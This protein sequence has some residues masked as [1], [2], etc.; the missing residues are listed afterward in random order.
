MR[1]AAYAAKPRVADA[2]R[3]AS[4]GHEGEAFVHDAMTRMPAAGLEPAHPYGLRILSPLRLPFRQAGAAPAI[5][6][7]ANRA[8][9]SSCL[10]CALWN[11]TAPGMAA[12]SAATSW[13]VAPWNLMVQTRLRAASAAIQRRTSASSRAG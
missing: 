1:P 12:K 11:S 2:A 8:K 5:G 4:E 13:S 10:F 6:Y 3:P 9:V 7:G